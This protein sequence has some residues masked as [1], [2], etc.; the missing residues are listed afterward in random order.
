VIHVVLPADLPFT[1]GI[2]L[3][4]AGL[5]AAWA[6]YAMAADLTVRGLAMLAIFRRSGWSRVRV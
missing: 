6:W 1:G 3:P 4:G 2:R 5:G